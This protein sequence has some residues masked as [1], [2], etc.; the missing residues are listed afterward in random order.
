MSFGVAIVLLGAVQGLTVAL[1]GAGWPA[2]LWR[3]RAAAWAL[4]APGSIVV[5]IFGDRGRF[6]GSPTGS[7][8]W[9]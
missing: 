9:R 7:P 2:W 6:P 4:V 3:P 5:V 1:P 8:G